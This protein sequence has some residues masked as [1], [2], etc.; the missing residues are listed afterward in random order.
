MMRSYFQWNQHVQKKQ[1]TNTRNAGNRFQNM[2]F[3]IQFSTLPII[4]YEQPTSDLLELIKWNA[5]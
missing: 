3:Y 1:P 2:K 4:Q 5:N